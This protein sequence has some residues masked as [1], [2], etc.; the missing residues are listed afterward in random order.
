MVEAHEKQRL[1]QL[2]E[3]L[4]RQRAERIARQRKRDELK[5][6][7]RRMK[8]VKPKPLHERMKEEYRMKVE[9]P[10][11]ERRKRRLAEIHKRFSDN[12]PDLPELD[13]HSRAH[14]AQ[15]RLASERGH[16]K[17]RGASE[18]MDSRM[19]YHGRTKNRIL[20][21]QHDKRTSEQRKR[22]EL[23]LMVQRKKAYEKW[24]KKV[25]PP[26]VDSGKASELNSRIRRLKNPAPRKKLQIEFLEKPRKKHRK[27]AAQIGKSK[28]TRCVL[29]Y[30]LT[31][32]LLLQLLHTS[33]PSE[34]VMPNCACDRHRLT[35]I[36]TAMY[37]CTA[38]NLPGATYRSST[39]NS[40]CI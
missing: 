4:D 5:Q 27:E 11:L 37:C 40:Q 3:R 24:V 13:M 18:W 10:E 22:R 30:V 20:K 7:E 26:R 1:S 39:F 6:I 15:R 28:R 31:R 32:L 34:R 19:W 14:A 8:Q 33:E 29:K 21:E 12:T 9:I 16:Q 36:S 35:L 25:A 38:P 23:K 17:K 2:K